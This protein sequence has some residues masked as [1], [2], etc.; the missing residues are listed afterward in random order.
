MIDDYEWRNM[1]GDGG[2]EIVADNDSRPNI[3]FIR[4]A[5]ISRLMMIHDNDFINFGMSQKIVI[6]TKQM[7]NIV[8]NAK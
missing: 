7:R 8:A 1:D 3:C 2:G 4:G 6:Y 5:E